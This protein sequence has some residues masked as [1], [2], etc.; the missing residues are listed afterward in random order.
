M[1][2]GQQPQPRPAI[3]AQSS[4]AREAG[5]LCGGTIVA[6]GPVPW[7]L[8]RVPALQSQKALAG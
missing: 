1:R 6:P 5:G 7:F 4:C 8:L 3:L 2:E